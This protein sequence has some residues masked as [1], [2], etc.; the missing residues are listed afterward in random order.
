MLDEDCFE[1]ILSDC[2]PSH[3][4]LLHRELL[5]EIE[6]QGQIAIVYHLFCDVENLGYPLLS[7]M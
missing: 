5:T 6:Y 2:E 3:L 1:Y 7:N 4:V